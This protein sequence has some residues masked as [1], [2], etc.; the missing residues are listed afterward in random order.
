M[1]APRQPP[2]PPPG[3]G[4]LDIHPTHYETLG[5]AEDATAGQV[6]ATPPTGPADTPARQLARA[7]L[8]DPLRRPVYDAWLA[9]ERAGLAAAAGRGPD[10]RPRW[11]RP[12][13]LAAL[14]L[15]LA[16]SAAVWLT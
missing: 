12:L 13:L 2:R 14:V 5:L 8:A 4:W 10:G 11:L 15:V 9:R 3:L 7:V 6:D 1:T 16:V